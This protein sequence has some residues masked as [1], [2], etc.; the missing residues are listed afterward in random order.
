MLVGG[1]KF[2]C[3]VELGG[4]DFLE[5]E[6]ASSG[7]VESRCGVVLAGCLGLSAER[8]GI[9]ARC[10]TLSLSLVDVGGRWSPS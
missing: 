2:W 1:M 7:V 10:R 5:V 3:A 8:G 6:R 4:V 9:R